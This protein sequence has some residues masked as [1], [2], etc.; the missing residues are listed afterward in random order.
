MN[1]LRMVVAALLWPGLMG[2]TPGHLTLGRPAQPPQLRGLW[3]DA[4]GPG[5]KTPAEID[6]LV[7]DA[8]KLNVNVLFAQVGRRGDCYC[9]RAAMPRTDD[10]AVPP[11]FDP[12]DDLLNKAHAAGI[13]VDAWIIT[14]ALWN[15]P[16]PPSSPQ[17]AFNLHGPAAQGR[18][19]WLTQQQ[20]GAQKAGNDWVLDPGHPDAAEYIRNMYVSVVKNYDVDGVQFD[21]VRY[22]DGSLPG[23]LLWGYNPTALER[24]RA[25][26]GAT[27]T[28]DPADPA[29]GA[30]RRQQV[31]NLVRE[32]A[33][34]LK[35]VRPTVSV[36]A[37]TI[38]YGAAP[39]DEA[40]FAATRPP[41]EVG[42]DWLT[43]VQDGYLDVNVMMNYKRDSTPQ[44]AR[45]HDD[46]A[47]FAA[48]LLRNYPHTA[49]VSG[50][51]LYLNDQNSSVSQ[52]RR[53]LRAGVSGWAMYSYRTP[54]REVYASRRSGA[55]VRPE[56]TAK[57]TDR[58]MPF[59]HP[60]PWPGPDMRGFRALSGHVRTNGTPPGNQVIVL[61]DADTG[62]E[63]ARTVTDGSGRYGFM[64]I[65]VPR[66]KVSAG[67][68]AASLAR[69]LALNDG[70]V[71]VAPEL[72]LP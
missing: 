35:A 37:A 22:P 33:L 29:W 28:P 62:R 23:A 34:A 40:S 39:T 68:A 2:C 61:T 11:G 15:S 48:G 67:Q 69:P 26:T 63:L 70:V 41:A 50:T 18:D 42:Q 58:T 3:V 27:G 30:W 44:Q 54:D 56:L 57:L 47:R 71:T 12:L 38:T 32:T 52:A 25:E 36:N 59:E 5:F 20:G 14:T 6:Q 49:Q 64:W 46:W 8:K 21:R 31:T 53:A 51:A 4:F 60:A 17:H 24:Y 13:A 65:A 10:P 1:R 43:W 19:N 66:V 9:N 72:T 7:L 55:E 45:Y 16:A